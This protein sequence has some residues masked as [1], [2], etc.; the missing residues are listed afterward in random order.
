MEANLLV[1]KCQHVQR[2]D[3]YAMVTSAKK[4]FTS[5]AG[6]TGCNEWVF[7]VMFQASELL[8][9]MHTLQLARKYV[10]SVTP[11][12][13]AQVGFLINILLLYFILFY[14]LEQMY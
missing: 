12:R 10:K 1:E 13:K 8:H 14:F 4:G 5:V 6:E 9:K 3:F 11:E 2:Y 7:V